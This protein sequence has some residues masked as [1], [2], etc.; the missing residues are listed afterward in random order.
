MTDPK[1]NAYNK[2]LDKLENDILMIK[3][4]FEEYKQ[5]RN[6]RRRKDAAIDM[7]FL[8]S[9]PLVDQII[10]ARNEID[11]ISTSF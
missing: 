8:Y 9:E 4:E 10:S 11:Y 6:K 3:N 1:N 7:M 5:L 2:K